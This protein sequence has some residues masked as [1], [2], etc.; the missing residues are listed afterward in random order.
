MSSHLRESEDFSTVVDAA[1]LGAESKSEFQ[2][3]ATW[4]ETVL[5]GENRVL[6][7]RFR[8]MAA[9]LAEAQRLSR[10]G[11]FGWNVA[12]GEL[13]LS[14]ETFNILG[15]DQAVKPTLD[16]VLSRVHPEDLGL[17][18]QIIDSASRDQ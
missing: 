15:Y 12:S 18:R 10:T 5:A 4:A 7:K 16:M 2:E 11:S 8:Q 6:E 13:T 3:D 9:Y 17:V 14:A 1:A